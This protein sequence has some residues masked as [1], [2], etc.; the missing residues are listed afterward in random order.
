MPYANFW[1]SKTVQ[2]DIRLAETFVYRLAYVIGRDPL[3]MSFALRYNRLTESSVILLLFLDSWIFSVSSA[4]VEF[5]GFRLGQNFQ[6][7]EA[8]IL[9]CLTLYMLTKVGYPVPE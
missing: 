7:C 8:A 9:I 2:R 6:A 1:H 4:L 3:P 5:G